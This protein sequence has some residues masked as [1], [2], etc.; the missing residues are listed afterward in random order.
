[1]SE[2]KKEAQVLS[3][4]SGEFEDMAYN[5]SQMML[6]LCRLAYRYGQLSDQFALAHYAAGHLSKDEDEGE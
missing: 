2:E 3:D 5:L 4:A 6:G 1:M